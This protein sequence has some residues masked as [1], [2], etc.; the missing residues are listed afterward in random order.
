MI[1]IIIGPDGIKRKGLDQVT[2]SLIKEAHKMSKENGCEIIFLTGITNN[3]ISYIVDFRITWTLCRCRRELRFPTIK[4]FSRDSE[5]A[6]TE[7]V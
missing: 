3:D 5:I 4:A 7:E 1:R 6:P 2:K